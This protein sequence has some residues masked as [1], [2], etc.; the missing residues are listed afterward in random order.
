MKPHVINYHITNRCNYRC[1]HCFA[2][3]DQ[4]EL[5][6]DDAKKVI[7]AIEEYFKN[8][9]IKNPRVNLAGGE[10]LVYPYID[11][12]IDYIASKGIKVSIITNGSYLSEERI[13]KWAGKVETIGISIDA[14][15]A[16]TNALIGRCSAQGPL[17]LE[18]T[19]KLTKLMREL[20][21]KF[22]INTVVTRVNLNEDLLSV[23]KMLKPNKIKYLCVH[24]VENKNKDS[25]SILPS[26]SEFDGFVER[27]LYDENCNVVVEN[28]GYMANSY[29]MINPQGEVYLNDN[30]TEK[31]YGCCLEKSLS[32]IYEILPL[33]EEKFEQ[34][35]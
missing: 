7:D 13:L 33:N 15:S 20:G 32:D 16:E 2:R 22:K 9:D 24:V 25:Q 3:F 35:Y 10:P 19:A 11:E 4:R 14:K 29:F 28:S 34:R 27:N 6:L 18:K 8:A 31:L 23:Y 12:V 21:I 5:S 30:G 26:T 1:K 17:D